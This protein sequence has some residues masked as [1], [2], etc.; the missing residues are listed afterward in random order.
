MVEKDTV[1]AGLRLEALPPW[2]T[3]CEKICRLDHP[4]AGLLL[5]RKCNGV[6]RVVHVIKVL[7]P[8][9]VVQFL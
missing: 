8:Q 9:V 7:A 5:L 3:Y 4:Q 6:C 2:T 1:W